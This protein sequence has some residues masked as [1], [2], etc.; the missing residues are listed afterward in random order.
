MRL[1]NASLTAC[2]AALLLAASAGCGGKE[3]ASPQPRIDPVTAQQLATISDDV[4]DLADTDECAAAARADDLYTAALEAR[5]AGH[6]PARLASELVA[7]T[8]ELRNELNCPPPPPAPTITDEDEDGHGHG[9]GK[10]KGKGK[11]GG[12]KE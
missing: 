10:G 6:V 7:R 9:K 5:D 1:P 11:H 12:D 3:K 8:E 4:A 2:S